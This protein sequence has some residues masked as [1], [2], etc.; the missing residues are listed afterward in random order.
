MDVNS[1][2]EEHGE[3]ESAHEDSED[4][5]SEGEEW[6][7]LGK[8]VEMQDARN[9]DPSSSKSKN[10]AP[11]GEE[12][13]AIRDATDLYRSS[14][15]K[16]QIDALLPNVR[17]KLS[18]APPLEKFLLKLHTFLMQLP[19]VEPQHPLEAARKLLKKGV[20]VPYCLPLPIEDTNWKVSFEKPE[21]IT[22]V[23]SWPNKVSVKAKD[24]L[25]Y[26]VDVA[27]QMPDGLF[28]E[29]DYL[30]A[31]FFQKKAFYLAT[32]ANS[33]RNSKSGLNVDV[34]YES[35]AGD[36]RLTKLV[37]T[38]KADGS[39]TD[40]TKLNARVC[41]IPTISTSSPISLHRLSPSHA[42]IRVNSGEEGVHHPSPLYNNALLT[43]YSPKLHLLAMYNHIQSIPA[44][45]DALTLL[46]IWANQRGFGEG[47]KLSVKGFENAGN[48]WPA[49]LE[50]V[51]SG[52]EPSSSG[53]V[54]R[55]PL[56]KGLSSYQLFKAAL[57]CLAKH[58]FIKNPALVKSTATHKFPASE[59]QE[60]CSA[61]LVDSSSL[62]NAFAYV[63]LGCIDM[64]RHEA[65][66]TLQTL[67]SSSLAIDPFT[68]V[69][70]HDH[71]DVATRF[72]I[73][74]QVDLSKAKARKLSPHESLDFGSATNHLLYNMNAIL[75]KALGD[76]IHAV[77]FLQPSSTS[78]V[79]ST[80]PLTQAYPST[81]STIF[82][83]LVLN[84]TH[85]FNL[86]HLGPAADSEDTAALA[87]FQELWGSKS[88]MRRFKDGRI[89]ESVV[90]DVKTADERSHVPAMVVRHILQWHFGLSEEHVQ[91]WQ[92]AYDSVIRLPK[93]IATKYVR[94]AGSAMGFKGAMQAFDRLV[95]QVKALEGQIPLS[96]VNISA[97]SESLRYTSAFNPVPLTQSLAASLPPNARYLQP[98]NIV[99]EFEQS[100]K[101]PDE[102]KAIQKI[103]LAFFEG[104]ATGLMNSVPG[105][106]ASVV[107]GS[108]DIT[109]ANELMDKAY[110]EIV[111]PEGWAFHARIWHNREATLLDRILDDHGPMP[112][113][114]VPK[115][116]KQAERKGKEYLDAQEAKEVYDRRFIHAPRHHRAVAAL[117]H[118]YPAFSG[119]CRLVKRWFASHWFLGGH[120]SE[121]VVEL[122]CAQIFVLDGKY[123]G[124]DADIPE[125]TLSVVPSTKER[126]FAMI[127][128][129]LSEW[130]WE[131]GGLY[132]CL[133]GPKK[134]GEGEGETGAKKVEPKASSG[135]VWTVATEVDK[136]GKVW[137]KGGPDGIVAR[138]VRALAGA[139]WS[140]LQTI[141]NGTFNVQGMFIHPTQDYDFV[142]QLNPF[143]LPR[144][145][146][147]IAANEGL[148]GKGKFANAR[149]KD[150]DQ[151]IVLPGFDPAKSLFTDL[152]RTYSDTFRLFADPYGGD[153]FGAVWDP[154]L[155]E[156][157]PFRVLGGFSSVPVKKESEKAKDKGLVALNDAGVLGEIERL[158]SGLIKAVVKQR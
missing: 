121:E 61:T 57:S 62:V 142:I 39:A 86:V 130:K 120:V 66:K 153:A 37:L 101:W 88:E 105:T 138:R 38:P 129:F 35:T 145:V 45:A 143:V 131:E 34:S 68:D 74:F 17:P 126:G 77:V 18:R 60:H 123:V 149:A 128:R 43:S 22:L 7:G 58:D 13:R 21:D 36:P 24:G 26:G 1:E 95:K 76:R 83:G 148:L 89:A 135:G 151:D 46:R 116:R 84:P 150:Q 157:R 99:F 87:E 73:V 12:V 47:S 158:G 51:I 2:N 28:Q 137:T 108:G 15:F 111:T 8:D 55:K 25:K 132:V 98:I 4:S 27:V 93:E 139:T 14:S 112:H 40:F 109:D 136:D 140:Y 117:S 124:S 154:T 42:N 63:P 92:S 33:I 30:N 81:S 118:Q 141:E 91:T 10:P 5:G 146:H 134:E 20:A 64:I 48:L 52:E 152:Q 100:A 107:L 16:L 114:V 78:D 104:I 72:D 71:R 23:G 80:R 106:K 156:P 119:T 96:L 53:A 59:Y 54:N 85:A 32:L 133:Y 122:L 125:N 50:L 41:I 75:R 103:K 29:K 79:P 127:M 110:L 115:K 56:G 19:A 6:N 90:W 67:Y 65:W 70:L 82:V 3:N 94:G 147:N 155:K 69:F 44:Y 102:L 11:T 113:V 9:V 31:R 97:T 144:Y 49:L